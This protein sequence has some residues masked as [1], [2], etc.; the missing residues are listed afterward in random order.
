MV[1][2]LEPVESAAFM[3]NQIP[4]EGHSAESP[5][6]KVPSMKTPLVGVRDGTP[7]PCVGNG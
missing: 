6:W 3:E 7:L 2:G 1:A 5:L 4:D